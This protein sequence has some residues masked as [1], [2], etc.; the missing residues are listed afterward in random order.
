MAL[1]PAGLFILNHPGGGWSGP[2][3]NQSGGDLR[4][5][6][7]SLSVS[8]SF[9]STHGRCVYDI[10]KKIAGSIRSWD[11]GGAWVVYP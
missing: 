9:L 7:L 4:D 11:V 8:Y 10:S 3:I 1:P 6:S 5:H 2:G